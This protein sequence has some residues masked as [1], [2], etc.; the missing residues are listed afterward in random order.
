MAAD[1]DIE[2]PLL[3]YWM[4][5]RKKESCSK[6]KQGQNWRKAQRVR[7]KL[8]IKKS[9]RIRRTKWR[10]SSQLT[11]SLALAEKNLDT[12]IQSHRRKQVFLEDLQLAAITMF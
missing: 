12:F 6:A 11:T 2:R 1:F 10:G 4:Q 5:K 3:N 8:Q 7:R 9:E